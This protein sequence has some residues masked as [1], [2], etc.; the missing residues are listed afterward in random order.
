MDDIGYSYSAGGENIAWGYRTAEEV[1]DGWMNSAGHRA[2]I[3]SSNFNRLG[4]GKSGTY[5]VQMF[6][7]SN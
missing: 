2:N 3:L 1:V 7:Y 6:A 5:W 4:V